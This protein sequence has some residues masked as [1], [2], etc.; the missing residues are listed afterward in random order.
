MLFFS[1]TPDIGAIS[2]ITSAIIFVSLLFSVENTILGYIFRDIYFFKKR[3]PM[4]LYEP[5]I[6]K[7]MTQGLGNAGCCLFGL[8][9]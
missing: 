8:K 3:Y 1:V 5:L 2:S 6:R 4:I 9:E 7:K